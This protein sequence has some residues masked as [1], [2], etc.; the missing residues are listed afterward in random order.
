MARALLLRLHNVFRVWVCMSGV[1]GG[2]RVIITRQVLN[3]FISCVIGKDFLLSNED[4]SG[5]ERCPFDSNLNSESW[6]FQ[7]TKQ[8]WLIWSLLFLSWDT[9]R[10]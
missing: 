9:N 4:F 6:R 7:L 2:V 10:D 3:Y 1:G 5:R 8:T